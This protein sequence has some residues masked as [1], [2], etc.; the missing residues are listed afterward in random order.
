MSDLPEMGSTDPGYKR[1]MGQMIANAECPG[2]GVVWASDYAKARFDKYRDGNLIICKACGVTL[3]SEE[4]G[5][6]RKENILGYGIEPICIE[7][8]RKRDE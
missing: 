5:A 6:F 2:Y 4:D 8:K 1:R 7:C 3:M